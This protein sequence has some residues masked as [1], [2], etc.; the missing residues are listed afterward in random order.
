MRGIDR[1]GRVERIIGK[2]QAQ[3]ARMVTTMEAYPYDLH[4]GRRYVAILDQRINM[5]ADWR[6]AYLADDA[7]EQADRARSRARYRRFVV[8]SRVADTLHSARVS[9]RAELARDEPSSFL[10]NECADRVDMLACRFDRVWALDLA[11]L[12]DRPVPI[13]KPA[14]VNIS[15]NVDM[16]ACL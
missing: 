13:G 16:F 14:K 7:R 8:A 2:L 1:I 11:S 3:R 5:L 15:E 4:A 10:V 6:D 9:L 12:S